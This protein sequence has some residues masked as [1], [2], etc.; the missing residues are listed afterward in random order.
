M[1]IEERLDALCEGTEQALNVVNKST[2]K[3]FSMLAE[4]AKSFE[5][6]YTPQYEELIREIK[7]YGVA[8]DSAS[9]IHDKILEPHT[10]KLIDIN[11]TNQNRG[12]ENLNEII[13]DA[14][15]EYNKTD[16]MFVY[17]AW[18]GKPEEYYYVGKAGSSS[19]TNLV[20][21]GKLLEALRYASYLSFIF[22]A[23]STNENI[24]NLEA[25]LIHLV[26][27]RTGELPRYN[28]RKETFALHY[29]CGAE[30]KEIRRLISTINRELE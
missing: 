24:Q 19:R 5:F 9:F 25:A 30:L 22:P 12:I 3:L 27:F 20:K 7:R 18:R 16:R 21:H 8:Y 10:S 13:A 26:E 23:M 14:L 28:Q 6:S 11:L 2:Q 15:A 4:N 17:F 29:E 1:D